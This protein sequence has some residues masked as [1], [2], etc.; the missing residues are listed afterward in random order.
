M[1]GLSG[2]DVLTWIGLVLAAGFVGYFG[3]HLAAKVIEKVTGAG[4]AS[5]PPEAEA[6]GTA[7]K[8]AKDEKKRIKA[9]VKRQKKGGAP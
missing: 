6:T 8:G 5:S 2:L 3:R 9:E 1:E 7:E 4:A